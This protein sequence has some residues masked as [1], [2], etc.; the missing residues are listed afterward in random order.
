MKKTS[1]N[2][3]KI[4]KTALL[5]ITAAAALA[6]SFFEHA[7]TAALPLPPGVKPGLANVVVMFV[8]FTMGLPSALIL[9]ALKSGFIF[10]ISGA[11]SG[12]I[13]LCGGLLSVV[14]MSVCRKIFK[15]R[16]SYIGISV[17][18]AVMHNFGQ[19]VA[20]SITVG[21]ALYL[22][23]APVLLISG[24]LFGCVTGMI[25]NA[26]LPAL[27]HTFFINFQN[28]DSED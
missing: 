4:S 27:L 14:S 17:V 24:I 15:D 16:L 11:A 7:L 22:A 5:G 13:S 25:L 6:V 10:L 1:S 26:V 18:S 2:H 20:S 8:C 19:L 23:Y 12:F 28:T 9:A 21:S 3:A